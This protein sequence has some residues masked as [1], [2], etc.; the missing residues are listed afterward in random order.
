MKELAQSCLERDY[1][2]TGN[3]DFENTKV[4]SVFADGF[5]LL[6]WNSNNRK[7]FDI[8][9]VLNHISSALLNEEMEGRVYDI[10][11]G[12]E[13]MWEVKEYSKD[14]ADADLVNSLLKE[15]LPYGYYRPTRIHTGDADLQGDQEYNI[16][17]VTALGDGLEI[18]NTFRLQL[19]SGTYECRLSLVNPDIFWEA[20]GDVPV[21][22]DGCL[23]DEFLHFQEGDERSEVWRWMES[24]FSISILDR[25]C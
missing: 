21:D 3:H 12:V 22:E 20:L 13:V 19:R 23:E 15:T 16:H 17:S 10:F 6:F 25:Y 8:P 18:T 5:I 14:Q 24:F 4:F 9:Y 1:I 7:S 11:I 2:H